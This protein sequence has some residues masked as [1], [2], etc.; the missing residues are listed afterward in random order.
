MINAAPIAV[1][2]INAS[3]RKK[4]DNKIVKSKKLQGRLLYHA[5]H[6]YESSVFAD[7]FFTGGNGFWGGVSGMAPGKISK[8]HQYRKNKA[9]LV[10]TVGPGCYAIDTGGP[11]I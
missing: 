5:D 2:S 11:T 9:T 6:V 8:H 7:L 1:L 3:L 4:T 10:R